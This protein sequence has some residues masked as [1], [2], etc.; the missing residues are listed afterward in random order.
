VILSAK[1]FVADI[2]PEIDSMKVEL[3]HD[4]I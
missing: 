3:D 1:R 2:T 4:L